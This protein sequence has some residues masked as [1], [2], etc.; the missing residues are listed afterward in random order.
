MGVYVGECHGVYET[1]TAIKNW[2]YSLPTN[3]AFTLKLFTLFI[4]VKTITKLN[5]EHGDKFEIKITKFSRCGSPSPDNNA[6][7]AKDGKEM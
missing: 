1:T 2:I 5:P 7:F 4:N 6:D 3:L